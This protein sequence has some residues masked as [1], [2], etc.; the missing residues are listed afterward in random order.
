MTTTMTII[1]AAAAASGST[2]SRCHRQ[3]NSNNLLPSSPAVVRILGAMLMMMLMMMVGTGTGGFGTASSSSLLPG[4]SAFQFR[5]DNRRG[6][7]GNRVYH[8]QPAA[9]AT[10]AIASSSTEAAP[11]ND[12]KSYNNGAIAPTN[13]AV[14]RTAAALALSV[15]LFVGSSAV[16]PAFAVAST[17][18]TATTSATAAQISLNN[19]PPNSVN[20]DIAD[21]PYVFS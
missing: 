19:L 21:L 4:V 1:T 17:A 20:I 8:R 10:F 12:N 3:R 6:F 5:V 15:A 14:R 18:A 7:V 16:E 2:T 11:D 13:S 9:T